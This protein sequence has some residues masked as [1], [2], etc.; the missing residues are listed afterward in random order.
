MMRSRYGEASDTA[1]DGNEQPQP[2]R[3]SPSTNGR[4]NKNDFRLMC[5][6]ER[7]YEAYAELHLLAQGTSSSQCQLPQLNNRTRFVPG[8]KHKFKQGLSCIQ[9]SI[10]E[11]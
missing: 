7:L 5:A 11:P 2:A 8:S 9:L 1:D 3:S 6:N 10:S 4:L